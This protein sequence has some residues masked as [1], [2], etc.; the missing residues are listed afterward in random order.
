M[1]CNVLAR[2]E[3]KTY[4]KH[5]TELKATNQRRF[6]CI[7]IY[8]KAVW[9]DSTLAARCSCSN[10]RS[11]CRTTVQ[12]FRLIPLVWCKCC[13]QR[14]S[15]TAM[16]AEEAWSQSVKLKSHW[17]RRM[18]NSSS[19]DICPFIPWGS[20][21]QHWIPSREP[22][23]TILT[24]FAGDW[25][26]DTWPLNCLKWTSKQAPDTGLSFQDWMQLYLIYLFI[27]S[28]SAVKCFCLESF[29]FAAV[30]LCQ[31]RE[32]SLASD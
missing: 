1:R 32:D 29:P 27:L 18:W 8:F 31:R 14:C 17:T 16:T 26:S 4:L 6:K 23:G 21:G 28:R 3:E 30:Q 22:I 2:L 7:G 9:C 24:V 11:D 15:S 20:G 5:Q 19:F 12:S 13:N 10:S 25:T